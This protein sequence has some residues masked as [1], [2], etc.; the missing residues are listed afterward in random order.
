MFGYD[1]KDVTLIRS[2]TISFISIIVTESPPLLLITFPSMYTHK[3]AL[4]LCDGNHCRRAFSKLPERHPSFMSKDMTSLFPQRNGSDG[5]HMSRGFPFA[6]FHTLELP[7]TPDKMSR[8]PP[9]EKVSD[10]NP[11]MELSIGGDANW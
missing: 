4:G 5:G 7:S 8:A 11:S 6:A 10:L 1:F 2:D 3:P 9:E